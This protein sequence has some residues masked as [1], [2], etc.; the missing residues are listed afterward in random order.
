M[1]C[2]LQSEFV[3]ACP[4]IENDLEGRRLLC[5][6]RQNKTINLSIMK[7]RASCARY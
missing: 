6:V 5:D 3:P 2:E 7:L 1:A 4:R